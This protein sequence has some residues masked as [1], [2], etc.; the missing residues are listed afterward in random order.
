MLRNL[1]SVCLN[2]MYYNE[3]SLSNQQTK[4]KVKESIGFKL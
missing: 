1:Y 2:V 3:H 4:R